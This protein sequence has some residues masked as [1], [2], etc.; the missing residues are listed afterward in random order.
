MGEQW[1]NAR[2]CYAVLSIL[3][4]NLQSRLN[5]ESVAPQRSSST[6]YA[7]HPTQNLMQRTRSPTSP[8][9]QNPEKR[10][11]IHN[12][13]AENTF[14]A[15]NNPGDQP[16]QLSNQHSNYAAFDSTFH[17]N[18]LDIEGFNNLDELQWPDIFGQ[19]SWEALFHGGGGYLDGAE[20]GS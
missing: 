19:V 3:S 4:S 7:Q 2:H 9:D 17:E 16:G 5:E 12:S 10:Q 11:R 1:K 15:V 14:I 6:P 20:N 8:D 18:D 13:E